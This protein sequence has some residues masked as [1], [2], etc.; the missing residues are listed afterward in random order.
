ME[1]QDQ[2]ATIDQTQIAESTT[3]NVKPT[4]NPEDNT[5]RA[6]TVYGEDKKLTTFMTRIPIEK[7]S[8]VL[9][10]SDENLLR[11]PVPGPEYYKD[12]QLPLKSSLKK[13]REDQGPK[14]G[15]TFGS[16]DDCLSPSTR[17]YKQQ[18]RCRHGNLPKDLP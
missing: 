11:T 13:R 9:V 7:L 3:G 10:S 17:R 6:K 15:V 14:K 5:R 2:I 16:Q 12:L 4:L 1:H 8:D 18:Q